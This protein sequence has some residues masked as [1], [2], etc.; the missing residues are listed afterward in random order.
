MMWR[1]LKQICR[2]PKFI[3]RILTIKLFYLKKLIFVNLFSM[4]RWAFFDRGAPFFTTF[5]K[6]KW[7]TNIV[8][9]VLLFWS[10]I[11]CLIVV[12][13]YFVIAFKYWEC[14]TKISILISHTFNIVFQKNS[15]LITSI[16]NPISKSELKAYSQL[17]ILK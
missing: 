11:T 4:H 9:Y 7:K 3:I 13:W 6:N 14:L 10:Y 16:W 17:K 8:C 12:F 2:R 15:I 5:Q 1:C